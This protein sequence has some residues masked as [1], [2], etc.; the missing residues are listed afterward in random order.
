MPIGSMDDNG[1]R[2]I[3]KYRYMFDN[4]VIVPSPGSIWDYPYLNQVT[5]MM[6]LVYGTGPELEQDFFPSKNRIPESHME[7]PSRFELTK[8]KTQSMDEMEFGEVK[9]SNVATSTPVPSGSIPC[10]NGGCKGWT[11]T[12][13]SP[14]HFLK[15][16]FLISVLV[17]LVL[18]V[19]VY[20]FLT[21]YKIL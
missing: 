9:T 13:E 3:R 12:A 20:A 10:R 2:H 1:S 11:S 6:G 15:T 19:I 17:A 5:S 21:Q 16:V 18:W 14:W 7:S 4:M 8:T